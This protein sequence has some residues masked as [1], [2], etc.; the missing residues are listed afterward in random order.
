MCRRLGRNGKVQEKDQ[1]P[2]NFPEFEHDLEKD[3][4]RQRFQGILDGWESPNKGKH[5]FLFTVSGDFPCWHHGDWRGKRQFS[6]FFLGGTGG[7]INP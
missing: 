5:V 2:G 7:N 6:L 4:I 3:R 1:P